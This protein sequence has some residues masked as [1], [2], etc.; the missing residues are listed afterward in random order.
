M[1]HRDTTY[2]DPLSARCDSDNNSVQFHQSVLF[3]NEHGDLIKGPVLDIGCSTG[4][5]TAYI[6]NAFN[7]P[8]TGVDISADR[9]QHAKDHYGTSNIQFAAGNAV[10]LSSTDSIKNT[11]YATIVSFNT[12]HY[13]PRDKHETAFCEIKKMLTD[14]GVALLLIPG[15]SPDIHDAIRDTA[16]S[17]QWRAYFNGFDFSAVRT[18]ETPDFYKKRLQSAGFFSV[19][20]Q[21]AVEAGG[22]EL[23]RTGVKNFLKGWLPHLAHLARMNI[24][25][26]KQNAFLDDIVKLY[27]ARMNIADNETVVPM[28][29]QNK[30]VAFSTAAAFF[31]RKRENGLNHS[32][33]QM[34]ESKLTAGI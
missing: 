11:K 26:A 19:E 34:V 10:T 17:S 25:E 13:L 18:Y 31:Q 7:T 12:L 1:L 8:I 33:D 21:A 9:V 6:G 14:D 23:D 15:R 29:T 27:F 4:E 3:I 20:T 5:L 30:V 22:K 24:A 32:A 28:I 16:V 2:T